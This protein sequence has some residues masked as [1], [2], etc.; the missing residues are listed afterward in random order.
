MEK[1]GFSQTYVVRLEKINKKSKK[2]II[3]IIYNS[4]SFNVY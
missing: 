4:K 1:Y 3:I 2:I